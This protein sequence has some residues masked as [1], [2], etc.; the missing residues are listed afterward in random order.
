[1]LL[2]AA[3]AELVDRLVVVAHDR[4]VAMRRG[5]EPDELGLGA[6]RVLELV[7]QHVPEPRLDHL[8]RRRAL[9]QE[10]QRERHLVAEVDR[11]VLG[12]Q[13][14]VR[15]VGAR[16]L[17]LAP[18][19]LAERGGRVPIGFG[20]DGPRRV[21]RGQRLG[22][23]CGQPL[24][25]RPVRVRR[26]VLVL[27]PREQRR[28]RVEELGRVAQR[29]V[30]LE[31]ELEHVLAQEHDRLRPRQ[32]PHVRRQP[33][34]EREL[35]DEPVAERVEGRDRRV[36]VAVR[37]ELVDPRL[38]LVRGLVGERQGEDLRPAGRAGSR[39]ATRSGG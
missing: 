22:G 31:P 27:R 6:V 12:E 25:V 30:R 2:I 20:G 21:H 1:M 29:P 37:D 19:L 38:H 18:R 35:P 11:P 14:L 16:E 17:R 8:A 32:H 23:A 5:H 10:P 3:P 28:E 26:D 15:R 36:R 34:L 39:S 4:D 24:G 33:Q 7:D 13:P 9:A